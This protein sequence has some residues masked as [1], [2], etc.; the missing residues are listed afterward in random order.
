ME[1]T[2]C[3]KIKEL[4]KG[5]RWCK[6]CKNEYERNRK[7]NMSEEQRNKIRE[8]E[9]ERYNKKKEKISKSNLQF[10]EIQTKICSVCR[11]EKN[12]SDFYIAKCKGT[13]RAMCKNCSYIKR[14]ERYQKNKEV[15]I[16]QTAKYTVEKMKR[17]P[18]FKLER[19]LRTR[20][21]LAFIAQGE[22][23]S[24]RTWKY[25]GC[26]PKFFQEWIEYQLYDGMT[27]ENYGKIQHIDHVKPCSSYDLSKEKDIDECFN[28]KN[29]RPLLAS[30]NTKKY[31]KIDTFEIV[32]QELKVK[33]FI[34]D[35]NIN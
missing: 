24:E 14:K 6:D 20:I 30:K 18:I 15:I 22:N 1:C 28:W 29:L 17:D 16:E 2:K 34:R 4:A 32:L 23:K 13:V 5:K 35:R 21:Y 12:V 25:I 10:D 8:K 27:M 19:R 9:R 31:N 7:A 11:I 3:H 33:C 26:S